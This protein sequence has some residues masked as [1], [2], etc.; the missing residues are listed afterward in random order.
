MAFVAITSFFQLTQ[1]FTSKRF[2]T[3]M[4][5]KLLNRSPCPGGKCRSAR[6]GVRFSTGSYQNLKNWCCSLL[7]RRTLCGI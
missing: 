5:H 7:A 1:L 2:L 3:G 4:E 6:S